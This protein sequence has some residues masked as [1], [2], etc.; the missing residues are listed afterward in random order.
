MRTRG[1]SL[2]LFC[3][4]SGGSVYCVGR[5]SPSALTEF[6]CK[7]QKEQLNDDDKV[8]Q[9]RLIQEHCRRIQKQRQRRQ[10]ESEQEPFAVTDQPIRR[11]AAKTTWKRILAYSC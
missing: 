11:V 6:R 1:L 8:D 10:R 9:S 4:G 3:N 7:K 5:H 2:E